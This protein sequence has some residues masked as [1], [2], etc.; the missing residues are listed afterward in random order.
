MKHTYKRSLLL[1]ITILL[2]AAPAVP[3]QAT[4]AADPVMRI[5][6][7]YGNNALPEARLLNAT[8]SGYTLGTYN[9]NRVFEPFFPISETAITMFKNTLMFYANESFTA[10]QTSGSRRIGPYSIDIG[11]TYGDAESLI[12]RVDHVRLMGLPAYPA[13]VN[14][15]LRIRVG[16]YDSAALAAAELINMPSTSAFVAVPSASCIT[17][18]N[19]NTGEII[20]Q[21][22]NGTGTGL[23]MRPEGAAKTLT[24]FRGYRYHGGFSYN[25][26]TGDNIT[27]VNVVHMQ[28]YIKGVVPYEMNPEWHIEALKAQAVAARSFAFS[29]LNH[30]NR[31]HGFDLCNTTC[32]QVYYGANRATAST[33]RAVDDTFGHYARHNGRIA[34]TVYH[35]SNGGHSESARNVWGSEI[36][37]LQAVR[38]P[39]E[40]TERAMRGIWSFQ[41][42]NEQITQI[43][44]DRGRDVGNI[45]DVWIDERTPSDNVYRLAMRDDRGQLHIFERETARII[46]N[47]SRLGLHVYSQRYWIEQRSDLTITMQSQSGVTSGGSSGLHV[48]TANGVMPL[49]FPNNNVSVITSTGVQTIPVQQQEGYTIHGRGWGN[50]VGMSQFGARAK[51]DL[52]YTYEQILMFYY[53]GI[54]IVKL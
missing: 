17:V 54:E 41:Y 15:E 51:A 45:V 21:Y 32:C 20:A 8:G 1:L 7:F 2:I 29:R 5:G 35:S 26:L 16:R 12:S 39:Y 25:R 24:W 44:R 30:H 53:Q 9:A 48:I 18:A 14:G 46:L 50:N 43:L 23:G 3:V 34:M 37:H 13:A 11:E 6:L 27:V 36:P 22:D 52:G 31:N 42:T 47:S 49:T 28:D 40:V 10:T 33:D 19:T 4:N 38:D